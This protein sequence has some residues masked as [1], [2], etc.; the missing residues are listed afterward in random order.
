MQM[1]PQTQV[2]H[3]VV[4]SQE[5]AQRASIRTLRSKDSTSGHHH[6]QATRQHRQQIAANTARRRLAAR[7]V[8]DWLCGYFLCRCATH[9]CFFG[10]QLLT[11]CVDACIGSWNPGQ[12][13]AC[14]PKTAAAK[15]HSTGG[16]PGYAWGYNPSPLPPAPPPPP[17]PPSCSEPLGISGSVVCN[18]TIFYKSCGMGQVSNKPL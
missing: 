15:G 5:A 8:C 3:R 17:P 13:G 11:A 7:S 4:L 1:Q 10:N 2:W 14:F 12:P 18:Q 16:M 6:T 9:A